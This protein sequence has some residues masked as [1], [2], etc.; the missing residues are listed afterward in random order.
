MFLH[1]SLSI[2][3]SDS[4]CRLQLVLTVYPVPAGLTVRLE[5]ELWS[6]MSVALNLG[7]LYCIAGVI[8]ILFPVHCHPGEGRITECTTGVRHSNFLTSSVTEH[9]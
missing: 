1:A 6:T 9:T 4:A 5:Y 2:S 8:A 7:Q 3:S